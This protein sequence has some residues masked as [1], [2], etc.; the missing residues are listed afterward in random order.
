MVGEIAKTFE[1]LW[2]S[3]HNDNDNDFCFRYKIS[4]IF[5]SCKL[6]FE[7]SSDQCKCRNVGTISA[8]QF[9]LTFEMI[10]IK[11]FLHTF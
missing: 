9:C 11:R 5:R 2:F 10:E 7:V 6:S 3:D 8:L 1:H 4:E